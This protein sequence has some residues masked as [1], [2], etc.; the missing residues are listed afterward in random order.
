MGPERKIPRL[1]STFV[2]W[3]VLGA[4]VALV[5]AFELVPRVLL[6]PTFGAHSD[7][8]LQDALGRALV[9]YWRSGSRAFPASLTSL[10]DY[11]FQWHAIKVAISSLLVIVLALLAT[12]LWQRYL[13]TQAWYAAVA[14]A[15]TAS[16]VFVTWV[17]SVNIQVTALPLIPLLGL[18]PGRTADG[19][20]AQVLSEM[21][22]GLTRSTSPHAH[23]GSSYLRWV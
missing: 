9:E 14:V 12:A 18:L 2:V 15:A 13:R 4:A 20:L 23:S 3:V 16:T 21:R 7:A 8:K 17:L 6:R 22:E 5:A 19:N 10:V 11:W 1:Q